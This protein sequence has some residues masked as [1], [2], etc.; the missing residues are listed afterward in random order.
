MNVQAAIPRFGVGYFT[1]GQGP[2]RVQV[3]HTAA[4]GSG[5]RL[6]MDAD[7]AV[8]IGREM[9]DAGLHAAGEVA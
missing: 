2:R 8:R 9:L 6:V 5:Q 7:E 1:T 4:D 3:W